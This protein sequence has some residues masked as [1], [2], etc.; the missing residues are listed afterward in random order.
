M[1]LKRLGGAGSR[2]PRTGLKEFFGIG[3]DR[4]SMVDSQ[5]EN[6]FN[7]PLDIMP[8]SGSTNSSIG[9]SNASN[10]GGS[11]SQNTSLQ[12]ALNAAQ[13]TSFQNA[14]NT[15]QNTSTQNASNI[16]NN[17]GYQNAQ[18]YSGLPQNYQDALL[19]SIIPQLSSATA[20]ME[21]NYDNY[22]NQAL[23]SY[24]Q[25]LNNALRTNIPKVL[26][27]LANRGIL[28]STEGQNILG[29]VISDSAIDS[30]NKGYSTAMQA[31]LLKANI[32]TILAQL[33]DLGKTSYGTS[34]GGS[35]GTSM[36]SSTGSSQG[37]SAG[38]S[39]GGSQGTS[40]GS[41]TGSSQGTSSAFNQGNSASNNI[42]T[43]SSFSQD[44]TV[45]YRTMAD[46]I[47]S[48]MG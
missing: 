25:M 29:K 2:N 43:G 22:T 8:Q 44:P 30:S 28:N 10:L 19:K 13:N 41:S 24:N 46:L 15:A 36:G 11:T 9:T 5:S 34:V 23:G 1:L 47:Q 33:A 21:G 39:I 38:S 48:M 18:N 40:S 7:M 37:T 42:S 31:A 12:N 4:N 17:S 14:S 32:P 3:G 27:A 20:N 35:Q 45:M 26:G 16:S 6:M